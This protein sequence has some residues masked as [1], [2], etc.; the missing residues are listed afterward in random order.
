MR[1]EERLQRD[2]EV[3]DA[4]S[5]SYSMRKVAP[6]F[7]VTSTGCAPGATKR[8]SIKPSPVCAA[9]K[10]ASKASRFLGRPSARMTLTP[11]M[12]SG[13]GAPVSRMHSIAVAMASGQARRAQRRARSGPGALRAAWLPGSNRRRLASWAGDWLAISSRILARDVFEHKRLRFLINRRDFK[14]TRTRQKTVRAF[15][16]EAEGFGETSDIV[17]TGAGRFLGDVH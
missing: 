15:V 5:A 1:L 10:S 3:G 7:G 9:A 17:R 2:G 14:L 8:T 4:H 11:A 16:G 12:R 13:H 6:S